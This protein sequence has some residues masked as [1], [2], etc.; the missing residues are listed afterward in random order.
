MQTY[1]Q[2]VQK[3]VRWWDKKITNILNVNVSSRQRVIFKDKLTI[4]LL[5]NPQGIVRVSVDYDPSENLKEACEFA[6]IKVIC[7]PIKSITWIVKSE[8]NKVIS[9]Q[10]NTRNT[11]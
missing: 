10:N 1:E 5:N 3:V 2:A 8:E 7:L 9:S 11:L 4:L 6:G